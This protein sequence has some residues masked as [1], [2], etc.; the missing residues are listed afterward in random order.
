[1]HMGIANIRVTVY[2]Y[3]NQEDNSWALLGDKHVK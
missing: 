3:T 2:M 1:M